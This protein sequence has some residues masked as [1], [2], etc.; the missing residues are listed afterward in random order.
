MRSGRD[1]RLPEREPGDPRV[2]GGRARPTGRRATPSATRPRRGWRRPA[3]RR[4]PRG[5]RRATANRRRPRGAPTASAQHDVGPLVDPSVAV[6]GDLGRR[7]RQGVARA[8]R[9][10]FTNSSGSATPSRTGY[11][12][13]LSG[14]SSWKRCESRKSMQ[15]LRAAACSV[16]ARTPANSTW[17]KHRR[18]IDGSRRVGRRRLRAKIDLGRRARRVR[19]DDRPV[20]LAAGR[21]GELR[22]STP[23]PSR[24]RP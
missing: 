5:T 7:Q 4:T 6:R 13:M 2:D 9:A 17:R 21:A 1:R 24:R 3:T 19:H 15:L 22:C 8:R 12:N 20:A 23:P 16:P 11:T 14:M 10:Y 18:S